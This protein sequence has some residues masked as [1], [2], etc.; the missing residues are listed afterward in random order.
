M[1]WKAPGGDAAGGAV[2]LW[3]LGKTAI[4]LQKCGFTRVLGTLAKLG[5]CRPPVRA[6][7]LKPRKTHDL[8]GL[9]RKV[10]GKGAALW[11]LGKTASWLQKCGFTRVLGT[12]AKL[13]FCRP[14]K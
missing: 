13:G 12:L 4:W 6:Q 5:F 1:I 8:E 11:R 3:G 14:P 2:H 10:G 7:E 9:R